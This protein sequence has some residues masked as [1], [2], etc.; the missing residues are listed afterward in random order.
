V[1]AAVSIADLLQI[2][3]ARTPAH[4]KFTKRASVSGLAEREMAIPNLSDEQMR[5]VLK[6]L[7]QALY[8]HDQW[9]EALYG[10]LICRL[11]PDQRDMSADAHRLCRSHGHFRVKGSDSTLHRSVPVVSFGIQV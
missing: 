7:E 9:A 10:A 11:Q 4:Q 5:T 6:A 3:A 2:K 8:N 1:S